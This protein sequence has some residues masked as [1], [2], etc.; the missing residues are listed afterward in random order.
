MEGFPLRE[1]AVLGNNLVDLYV[2]CGSLSE[3]CKVFDGLPN[4]NSVTWTLL[5]SGYA[6]RGDGRHALELYEEMM[7]RGD[8]RPDRALLLAVLKAC[9][10]VGATMHGMVTHAGAII[11][12]LD[13]DVSIGNALLEMYAKCG[14]V[15]EARDVFARMKEHDVVS[16]GTMLCGFAR[17][18]D[19]A[20]MASLFECMKQ[21]AGIKPDT[22]IFINLLKSCSNTG[23]SGEGTEHFES[24]VRS[25]GI[26]PGAEHLSSMID[27]FGRVGQLSE[28]KD[29]LVTLP[30]PR[31]SLM[32]Q[33]S[34]LANCRTYGNVSL[35][36]SLLRTYS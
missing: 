11:E 20:S 30:N 13:V 33:T 28:A 10:D 24:M 34:L 2:K 14:N 22:V 1:D 9:G 27:L 25:Y 26:D 36:D 4:R 32:P 23:L 19:R 3:A 5:I 18:G 8:V 15:R 29:L 21:E 35:G 7:K 17:L 12:G 31:T 16:W 6:K